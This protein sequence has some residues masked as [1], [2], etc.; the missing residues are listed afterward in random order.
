M[1][2]DR[3]VDLLRFRRKQDFVDLADRARNA[4]QWELAEQ[5]YREA[6]DRSPDNPPIWVQY[7]HALKES[8]ELRDPGKLAQ[9]E[10]AYRQALSLD[11]RAA[12][13]YL[14]LGHVLKLQEKTE[15]ARAAYLRGFALDPSIPYP[16]HELGGLGWSEEEL[17]ELRG[18]V[19]LGNH[20]L[21]APASGHGRRSVSPAGLAIPSWE[22][23]PEPR[24]TAPH[25]AFSIGHVEGDLPSEERTTTLKAVVLAQRWDLAGVKEQFQD[26]IEEKQELASSLTARIRALESELRDAH[27]NQDAV[28][29][30]AKTYEATLAR[31]RQAAAENICAFSAELGR[32]KTLLS[33]MMLVLESALFDEEYYRQQL[34]AGEIPGDLPPILYY[35]SSEAGNRHD[36]HPLFQGSHYRGQLDKQKHPKNLL[37]H[38]LR[39]DG[40][41]SPNPLFSPEYYISQHPYIRNSGINPLTHYVLVGAGAGSNPHPLFDVQY[42]LSQLEAQGLSRPENPLAHYLTCRLERV[43]PHRM[44]DVDFYLESHPEIEAA[45]CVPLVHYL[46]EG[47]RLGWNPHPLFDTGFYRKQAAERGIASADPLAHFFEIGGVLGLSPH[48]L[49]DSTYY[50]ERSPD[51]AQ[52]GTNPLQH[53]LEFGD[54][55]GLH[56]PRRDP[57]PLFSVGYYKARAGIGAGDNALLHY[58]RAGMLAAD[59]HPLFDTTFYL[60]ALGKELPSES[61]PLIYYLLSSEGMQVS[62]FALFDQ[63]YYRA[64]LADT[65]DD[66]GP[67][68][69]HYLKQPPEAAR[70]PHPLFDLQFFQ[71]AEGCSQPVLLAFVSKFLDMATN[72]YKLASM[73][74]REANRDFCSISYLLD[75]P[76]LL[77]GTEIPLV[78]YIRSADADL[79]WKKGQSLSSAAGYSDADLGVVFEPAVY[80]PSLVLD[81]AREQVRRGTRYLAEDDSIFLGG[82]RRAD[83]ALIGLFER[84]DPRA[85]G[86]GDEREVVG[87]VAKSR[88]LAIYA[89]YVP[90]GRLRSYHRAI[91]A[92]LR[93][94]NYVT[95][96]VNSTTTGAAALAGDAAELAQVVVV[97]S[98]AGRD[99]ASWII[100]LAHLAPALEHADHTLLL[101]DSLIGPFGDLRSTLTSLEEDPAD[102]KGLTD[103]F[104]REYHLQSSLLML[105]RD[106]LFSSAFLKFM[107]NFAPPTTRHGVVKEGEIGLS[108]ELIRAGVASSSTIPYSALVETWLRGMTSWL[109]WAHCMPERLEE[110]GLS[111]LMRPDVAARFS[112]FLDDWL[113]DHTARL[114][115]GVPCNPQHWL[116]DGLITGNFP[117]VKK[118]LLLIN[119][120]HIPTII[121]LYDIF[122][123][124]QRPKFAELLRDLVPP[125]RGLPLSYLHLS[126]PLVDAMNA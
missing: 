60:S 84:C 23:A 70:S 47:D 81:I 19:V 42:Y 118:D 87:A 112:T 68:L 115:S 100:A 55:E 96:L 106:A 43:S 1:A 8:G 86:R 52:N 116:W 49:F 14:Q 114:R 54:R 11:P 13:T 76:D 119:P 24:R 79:L 80:V 97:R 29:R 36:P 93:N 110:T 30:L 10:V 44:F 77:N 58:L 124:N 102:F 15:E 64:Q 94:A 74:F 46:G 61:T 48:P 22:L 122:P 53:Y 3:V 38:Y 28:H 5:L 18:A 109:Q 83:A 25:S 73:H 113:F 67:L 104:E 6:L 65:I 126:D 31:F 111:R 9:A 63:N 59:P 39:H 90:D 98:G 95:I 37:V 117:F 121:R 17:S 27:A 107:L 88:R 51:V 2:L 62:P 91:L 56:D 16:L 71:E 72:G 105:S 32:D 26:A 4:R 34:K 85:T 101:N 103:S 12:D 69:L 78:H 125:E 99:F 75:H 20:D 33:D 82:T 40:H 50:L 57:H 41:L 35:L 108:M 92:A 120:E 7:G 45:D 123:Q 66:D 21:A 89:I